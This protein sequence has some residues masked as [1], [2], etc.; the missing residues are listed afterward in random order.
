[1][2]EGRAAE[3]G[4][5]LQPAPASGAVVGDDLLEDRS[6]GGRVDGLALADG[7]RAGGLVLV[8]ARDDPLWIG[9]DGA[10]V[11]KHVDVIPR[12]QQRADV[13]LEDEVWAVGA[14]DGLAD[15]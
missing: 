4:F 12:R 15:L 3:S 14:L 2:D 8:A 1:M 11:E 9:D 7:H 13:A 6:Q 10:V 5:A